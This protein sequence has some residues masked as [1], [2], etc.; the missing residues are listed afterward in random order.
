[1]K[2]VNTKTTKK[3]TKAKSSLLTAKSKANDNFKLDTFSLSGLIRYATNEGAEH[4]Q[5]FV[6]ET[7]K[8]SEVSISLNRL[9]TA[10]QILKLT[11]DKEQ[12]NKDGSKRLKWSYWHLLNV[13]GRYAKVQKGVEWNITKAPKK[14]S[15]KKVA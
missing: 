14:S 5:N 10:K 12:V 4:L 8:K 11:K 2:K 13:V 7:E 9:L 3:T 1:M 6:D 15:L